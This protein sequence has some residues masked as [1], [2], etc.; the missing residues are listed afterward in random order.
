MRRTTTIGLVMLA[1][2]SGWLLCESNRDAAM[3]QNLAASWE[4]PSANFAAIGMNSR[5]LY[6]AIPDADSVGCDAFVDSII[7]DKPMVESLRTQGFR[8][9]RCGQRKAGL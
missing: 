8:E 2:A 9:I 4:S 1:L 5:T 6:V 3:R 7:T